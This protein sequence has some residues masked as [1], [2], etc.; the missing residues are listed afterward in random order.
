MEKEKELA[1]ETSRLSRVSQDE[2]TGPEV[3]GKE[4]SARLEPT[5]YWLKREVKDP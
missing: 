1:Q 5:T 4:T 3:K 2:K